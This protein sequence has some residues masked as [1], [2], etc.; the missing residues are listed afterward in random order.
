MKQIFFVGFWSI[1][2]L[3]TSCAEKEVKQTSGFM[4][5]RGHNIHYKIEGEGRPVVLIH[6]GFMDLRMWDEQANY[7][8]KNGFKV[9][10]YSDIGHGQTVKGDF[11]MFGCDILKSITEEL[12]EEKVSIVGMSFGAMTAMDF[13]LTYPENIK[14]MVLVS[15][16]LN[17]WGYFIDTLAGVNS[18]KRIEALRQRNLSLATEIYLQNWLAGPRRELSNVDKN[19]R[20]KVGEIVLSNMSDHFGESWSN[21]I[22]PKAIERME[23]VYCPTLVIYGE[24][25]VGDTHAIAEYFHNNITECDRQKIN[26]TAHFLNFEKPKKLNKLLSSFLD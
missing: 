14:N 1:V 4:D 16:G 20:I 12:G 3:F 19:V 10:R 2:I 26:G 15:P 24:H 23:K 5:I 22:E 8:A 6:G 9:I 25:D 17:G 18:T 7:L 21:L 11:P 13:A